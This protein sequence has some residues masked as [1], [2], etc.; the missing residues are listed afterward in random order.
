MKQKN[1]GDVK[2]IYKTAVGGDFPDDMNFELV[3][4]EE[5]RYG[6]NPNQPGALYDLKCSEL[7]KLLDIKLE[8]SGK[9][10][11]SG[12]NVLDV[13]RAID[14]LKFFK[15]PSVAVMKHTIPSGFAT[16]CDGNALV[17]IY[18]NARDADARSAFGSV[19][20]FNREVDKETA[21]EI[22]T[23]YVEAVAA[24]SFGSGAQEI[25][26]SKKNMRL[27]TFSNLDKIPKY[28]GED[29]RGLFD[30]KAMPG[31][32]AL[33]QK[34]FLTK[35][36]GKDDLITKPAVEDK[37]TGKEV[38]VE[39]EP[40][41]QEIKDMLASWYVN[42]GVRSNGVVIVKNG[43]TLAI[44]SGQQERVGAV[45]QAILKAYQKAMDR[46]GIKF[47]SMKVMDSIDKMKENPLKG[48]VLSSDGF[49]PFRDSIDLISRFGIK[50]VI[51]PGGSIKDNE[52]IKA[53]ND[54]KMS[55]VLTTE[56]CFAHF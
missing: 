13:A 20:V 26:S 28:E 39:R 5:L 38:S 17:E 36:K 10:G 43:T 18:K 50:A 12:T 52:V 46:E 53:A 3:N 47:D 8:K 9:G 24:P 21:E 56:R 40:T 48:A 15:E 37:E 11:L 55:M 29:S 23:S 14:I 7:S 31:G 44:G 49:F 27:M 51:Q 25:L 22:M 42:I 16:E 34:I 33:V 4:K 45:E 32:R 19:V 54:N 30:V 6:E 41:E 35:I 2:N 1:V